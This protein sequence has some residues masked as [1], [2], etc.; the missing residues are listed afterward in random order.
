VPLSGTG[1]ECRAHDVPLEPT[2]VRDRYGR[3]AE[4]LWCARGA[5]GWRDERARMAGTQPAGPL[6]W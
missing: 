4:V 3:A 5:R 1:P 6:W 2:T